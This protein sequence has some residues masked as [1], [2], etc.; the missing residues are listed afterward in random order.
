MISRVRI[1]NVDVGVFGGAPCAP[2]EVLEAMNGVPMGDYQD[3][4]VWKL[5]EVVNR[6]L[7]SL[8]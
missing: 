4:F 8:M 3:R 2:K 5:Y 7:Y 1:K 6:L